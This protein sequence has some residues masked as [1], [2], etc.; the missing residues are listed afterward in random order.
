MGL[1][2]LLDVSH[3]CAGLAHCRT[4]VCMPRLFPVLPTA[5]YWCHGPNTDQHSFV[6]CPDFLAIDCNLGR[7]E[8]MTSWAAFNA[9]VA[10]IRRMESTITSAFGSGLTQA[11]ISAVLGPG[12]IK[13]GQD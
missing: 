1:A 9:A 11:R 10:G 7:P 8:I 3:S 2:G 4:S 13:G 5:M 6:A 12:S